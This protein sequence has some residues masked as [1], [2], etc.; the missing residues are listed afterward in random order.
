MSHKLF[1]LSLLLTFSSCKKEEEKW[2]K[3][4]PS[5]TSG[6]TFTN[7]ITE[8]DQ[9]NMIDYSYLYNGGGVGIGDVNNDGLPD[10]FFTSNQGS[11]ELY[12]NK[13]SLQFENITPKAQV[14]TKGWCTGVTFVDIN[15]DGF[16]DIYICKSGNCPANERKNLLFVNDG[17][18]GGKW[19]GT[20][21]EQAEKYGIANEG[22]STQAAFFDY[23]KDG[24]LDLYVLN[25]TNEDRQ[26][27]R[28]K[29]NRE[30]DGNSSANDAFYRNDKGKFTE[31]HSQVGIID[32]GWGLGL[33]V[34]DF[35]KDGWED[36]Y[37]SNDF[38][39]HDLIYFNNQDGR[40]FTE[41]SK[42]LLAHTSH[43][44]MGNDIADFNND[45]FQDIIVADMMPS[46]NQQ[47]K[48]MAGTLSND[49]F[50]MVLHQGYN[51]QYMRNTLQLNNG[52]G[53]P[54][55]EIAMMAGVNATDWSWSPLLADFD[56]DGWKDLF[57][58]NGYRHD[59]T[60]MDFITDN[61]KLGQQM[62]LYD[63]DKII[64]ETAK[65][66]PEYKTKNRLFKNTKG[67]H[68]E[69]I[70][71]KIDENEPS[72]TNGAIYSDLDN[73]G[74]LDLI[75][76]NID[77]KAE[78]FENI[79]SK[80][81]YL[82]INL[83]EDSP[84][85]FCLG[86]E[87]IIYQKNNTQTYHHSVTKGYLSSTDY[88]LN[89]G[90]GENPKIDSLQIIW[91]DRTFQT[92]KNV[93]ANQTLAIKKSSNL[94]KYKFQNSEKVLFQ[95]SDFSFQNVEEPYNDFAAEPL[96]PRR[97]STE[98]SYITKGDINADGLEDFFAA[99]SLE[100]TGTFF[101]Q[102]VDGTF[103]EITLKSP[104]PIGDGG[105]CLLFDADNDKDLDLYIASGGNEFEL[106]SIFY[107]DQFF[108]NDGRGNFKYTPERLPKINTPSSCV[109]A[110]DYDKD[111]DLDLFVGGRRQIMKYGEAGTSRL[112]QNNKGFFREVSSPELKNIGMITTALWTDIDQDGWQDL[113][114]AG[115][116]MP[117]LYLKNERGK[118]NNNPV[119]IVE[120]GFWNTIA[121]A[122]F[123][124]DGDID[125]IAGNIGTN[126]KFNISSE[127]PYRLYL[128]DFDGNGF[129]DPI[130]T[131]YVEGKEYPAA[132]RDDLMK[133]LPFL[134]K[135][136]EKYADYSKATLQDIFSQSQLENALI[137]EITTDKSVYLE[138]NKG[139]FMVK[140]LPETA[141]IS[142]IK[143]FCIED[144]DKDGN[145]DII[146]I[147]NSHAPEVGTG[148][149]DASLGIM[150]KG[151]GKGDFKII[152]PSKS[153]ILAKGDTRQILKIQS[154]KDFLLI[155]RR[156]DQ[157]IQLNY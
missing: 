107:Q 5:E 82:K 46:T 150:L 30:L 59:I 8:N 49:A 100:K 151:T 65:K 80:K 85:R 105:E 78:V 124:K 53:L 86:A 123:D 26:P 109:V 10:I 61:A 132:N 118:L 33:G 34:G 31:I 11:C 139:K 22:W 141:Q 43:F 92:L 117:I 66:Q 104:V 154:K 79:S 4:V 12:L 142:C 6:I 128:K 58:S 37:I 135:K 137:K 63:A 76:N 55:S 16:L 96:L 1:I 72:F 81:N 18:I 70:S 114:I 87:V 95:T 48:K 51:P 106:N 145:L 69:D 131:Y 38:L 3:K 21:T 68:F 73:D 75:T 71:E 47:R 146:A 127:T 130:I 119:E 91:T 52:A 140:P 24:D 67:L 115:E 57:I 156:N 148:R 77:E 84:N 88:T 99:G 113:L 138:N 108:L 54:F 17:I 35:D 9:Y 110:S 94:P 153:G 101:I 40:G 136:I 111:G 2:F 32:D 126:N 122:D 90:L 143:S 60:D 36:L 39:A 149:L 103:T 134:R 42:T 152:S 147:G 15:A 20:F 112:L 133:Q 13:K 28:I 62:Q 56:N 74:D 89:I 98:G 102:K 50:E 25:A 125:L 83:S 116:F 14:Q 27:N 155:S 121:Q 157:F 29:E 129:A 23:D 144:F 19:S 7:T 45:G 97:F 44:S 93:K 41:K 64:K 120:K